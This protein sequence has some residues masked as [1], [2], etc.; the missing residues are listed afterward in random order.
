MDIKLQLE[1]IKDVISSPENIIIQML[2]STE[3]ESGQ[4]ITAICKCL[5]ELYNFSDIVSSCEFSY[6][7]ILQCT[8]YHYDAIVPII[9]INKMTFKK[10]ILLLKEVFEI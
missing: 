2:V 9:N 10:F 4:H 8:L 7:N 3:S 1:M 5:S 6:R